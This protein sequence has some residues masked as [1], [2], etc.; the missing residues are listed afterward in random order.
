M[1]ELSN[2]HEPILATR[3]PV[4]FSG[5]HKSISRGWPRENHDDLVRENSLLMQQLKEKPEVFVPPCLKCL[6]RSNAE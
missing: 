1:E 2:P 5:N 6:E 4:S 3:V